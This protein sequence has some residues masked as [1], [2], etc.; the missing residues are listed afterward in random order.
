[1][2]K[3]GFWLRMAASS[4]VPERGKPEMKWNFCEA[5][6]AFGAAGMR[7]ISSRSKATLGLRRP[8]LHSMVRAA[9]WRRRG[10]GA[11]AHFVLH[12]NHRGV[13]LAAHL[14]QQF[15]RRAPAHF[16]HG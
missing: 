6:V 11:N 2:R 12:F 9:L 3:R 4:V 13:A 15:L 14:A 1:A 10:R 16:A 8:A 7:A 5:F